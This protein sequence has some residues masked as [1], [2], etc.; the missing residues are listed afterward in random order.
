MLVG[1]LYKAAIAGALLSGQTPPAKDVRWRLLSIRVNGLE[2]ITKIARLPELLG[3]QQLLNNGLDKVRQLIEEHYALGNEVYRDENVSL[4]VV[5]DLPN[6]L[7][8]TDNNN[9]MLNTLILKTFKQGTLRNDS[10]LALGGEVTPI[11]ELDNASWWGQDPDWQAKKAAGQLPQNEIPS[12]NKVLSQSIASPASPEEI[13]LFW[14]NHIAETCTVCGIRPQGQTEKLSSRKVC[15]ICDMR[16]LD[17]CRSWATQQSEETIWIDEVADKNARLALITGQF[18]LDDWLS[19]QLVE[20]LVL[21][22][23]DSSTTGEV[24]SPS[25]SRIRR[26]W[27]TTRQFWQDVKTDF[28]QSLSD[29][30]RRLLL[31][32]DQ[33]P[34]LAPFH[35][36]EMDLGITT[37]SVAWYPQQSDG[38]GG[39]LIST[40]NLGYVARQLKKDKE[41]FTDPAT[42]A[43]SVEDYVQLEFVTTKRPIK[44]RNSDAIASERNQNLLV[45]RHIVRTEHQ[46]V[47]YSTAIPILSEP[48][49]FMALVPAE[50]SLDVIKTIQTKYK[51]EMGKVRN[52]LPIHLGV[53]YFQRRTPLRSAL[54]AGRQ[55]L[56]YKSPD[57][58]QI[59]QVKSTTKDLWLHEIPIIWL[60][61]R[62]IDVVAG[63][64]FLCKSL[65]HSTKQFDETVTLNLIQNDRTITW[66]VPT[67]MGDGTTEDVW[68][69]YV[70]LKTCDDSGVNGRQRAIK[71]Q[72]PGETTPCWLVHAADLREGDQIYFTTST[73]DFEFLDTSARRFEIY[74]DEN[75][76]RPRRTRPFYLEDLDR[77]EK[78]WEILK[79]LETSQ[80]HQVIHTIE[81]IRETWYGQDE[82]NQSLDDPV[83]QQFVADT[84][85]NATWTK[86]QLWKN[87]P[88]EQHKQL[89]DAGVRGEL[90]DLAELHMEILK[91][92]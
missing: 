19:G 1:A 79:K 87:I 80:C 81:A 15:N 24:K 39:Y 34:S 17:R 36:Y 18:D 10:S 31:Y 52:R 74:Y 49:T 9:E 90:A 2:Y 6:L 32:L 50:K 64:L 22:S 62:E 73:F 88:E 58:Q 27:E 70:F 72:R 60:I 48:R 82:E 8:F 57:N 28:N 30:R 23:P 86:D 61:I 55:M 66:H 69:P 53:V 65:A 12:V 11:I 20:S 59:W 71:S 43:I 46:D 14:Q 68:Y 5:A 16:R 56:N 75:G 83:F 51:Q 78:L 3:R 92:R 85:A 26:I 29:S 54:D 4:F 42:A 7:S 76:R 38:N 21:N 63:L 25:F 13:K 67:R 35:V 41:I 47:A 91:E 84:L 45:G 33:T 44:L 37:L 77:F 89:I 40:D